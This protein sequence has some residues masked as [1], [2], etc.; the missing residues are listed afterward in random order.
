MLLT[1]CLIYLK[2]VIIQNL[3]GLEDQ[4]QEKLNGKR[5]TMWEAYQRHLER[6]HK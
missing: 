5:V 4:F 1:T 6:T 3:E 2:P